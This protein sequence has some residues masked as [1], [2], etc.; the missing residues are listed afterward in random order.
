MAQHL[1]FTNNAGEALDAAIATSGNPRQLFILTD[2]NTRQ[3]CMPLIEASEAASRA[4]VISIPAG[5]ENKS[6]NE[7]AGVWQA[8][9]DNG[10]TRHSLMI[11]LGGGMVTDLGGFAAST[12]KRGIRFINIPTTLLSAVDAAV[13]GKTGINF[14]GLKNEI[15]VFSEASSVIISPMFYATLPHTELLSGYGEVLKH[16]LIQSPQALA[17]ALSFD[18]SHTPATELGPILEQSVRIKQRIVAEDPLEHGIRRALNL[19][20]TTAHALESLAMSR[21]GHL[22]HGFA[23]A[24][25]LVV[26]LV[27]SHMLLQFP[28]ATLMNVAAFVKANYPAP[29]IDCEDYP[30]IIDY[31][32][33]DKKNSSSDNINFTLLTAPG[34]IKID[35]TAP[36]KEIE[37]ALDIARDLL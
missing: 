29:V 33:H 37:A 26:E 11:N 36:V 4:T 2:S 28:S 19:G 25:G 1:T 6:L 17:E 22:P 5:D 16:A 14:N 23:V 13:G 31:M 30:L 18:L 20:H 9:G 24:Y 21:G 32:R 15:G 3:L 34:E 8:L 35:C 10:A 12:F 7:L 27:L